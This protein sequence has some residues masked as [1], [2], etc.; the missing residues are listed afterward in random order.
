MNDADTKALGILMGGFI[1]FFVTILAMGFVA[2]G[3]KLANLKFW[4]TKYANA[5]REV[6][7]ESKSYNHGMVRDLQNLRME[8]ESSEEG[9]AERDVIA[10]TALHRFSAYDKG[11]LP[12][13]MEQF[14]NELETR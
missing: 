7:E 5:E 13:E 12:P 10:Q 11:D 4:G 6:F 2:N 3:A 1:L 8:Y 14:L 9:S